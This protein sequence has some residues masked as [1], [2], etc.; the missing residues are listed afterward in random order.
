VWRVSLCGVSL[1]WP[2][3]HATL[4]GQRVPFNRCGSW[5]RALTQSLAAERLA[6]APVK[7]T[8]GPVRFSVSPSKREVATSCSLALYKSSPTPRTLQHQP[9]RPHATPLQIHGA[10]RQVQRISQSFS[11]KPAN[12]MGKD[13]LFR[14]VAPSRRVETTANIEQV[15]GLRRSQ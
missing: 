7:S 3:A 8:R 15:G 12:S 10:C 4:P 9:T 13:I 5:A 11:I 1:L 6:R 2:T 14:W